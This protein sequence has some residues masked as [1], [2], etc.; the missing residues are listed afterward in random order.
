[1]NHNNE[2]KYADEKSAM[3]RICLEDEKKDNMIS[4]CLCRGTHKYIH[5]Q[6]LKECITHG[7]TVCSSCQQEYKHDSIK[8]GSNMHLRLMSRRETDYERI[9]RLQ[10]PRLPLTHS[11]INDPMVVYPGE[12][13][14]THRKEVREREIIYDNHKFHKKGN[15]AHKKNKVRKYK[16]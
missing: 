15:R 6:C 4:P 8:I 16:Y 11:P 13:N 2:S 9:S 12:Y 7:Y 10:P 5:K 3:C 14:D 1:M